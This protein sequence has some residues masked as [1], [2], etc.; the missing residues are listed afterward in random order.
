MANDESDDFHW[1]ASDEYH[2]FFA[3]WEL[4]RKAE[5]DRR[6]AAYI[7]KKRAE[8]EAAK[9]TVLDGIIEC[10]AGHANPD[11]PWFNCHS[12]TCSVGANQ[13]RALLRLVR[14][15]VLPLLNYLKEQ[16]MLPADSCLDLADRLKGRS[17][18]ELPPLSSPPGR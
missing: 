3:E 5:F 17:V 11:E 8:R 10:V 9:K 16:G 4:S 18:T 14:D 2:V 15:E 12:A 13:I 6:R 7:A 1:T